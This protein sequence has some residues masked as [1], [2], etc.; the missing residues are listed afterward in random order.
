MFCCEM[1]QNLLSLSLSLI[2]PIFIGSSFRTSQNALVRISV[3]GFFYANGS[4]FRDFRFG[5]GLS[6]YPQ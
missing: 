2:L 6:W 5:R 4:E 3:P 1:A